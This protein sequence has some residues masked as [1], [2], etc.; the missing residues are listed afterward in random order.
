M[1]LIAAAR[2]AMDLLFSASNAVV[3]TLSLKETGWRSLVPAL[4]MCMLVVRLDRVKSPQPALLA[5]AIAACVVVL[6]ARGP[7]LRSLRLC[8]VV[9]CSLSTATLQVVDRL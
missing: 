6:L 5:S 8:A 9:V 4:L 1:T 3:A 7:G 2:L